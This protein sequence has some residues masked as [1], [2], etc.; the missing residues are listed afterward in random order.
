MPKIKQTARIKVH[1]GTEIP[2]L[3]TLVSNKNGKS[4]ARTTIKAKVHKKKR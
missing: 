4:A 3:E 1:K 2:K